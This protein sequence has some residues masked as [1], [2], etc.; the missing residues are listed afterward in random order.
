MGLGGRRW[1]SRIGGRLPDRARPKTSKAA[2]RHPY[3]G[4][5]GGS[6]GQLTTAGGLLFAGDAGGN[7]VAL[8]A[9]T[10]KPLWHAGLGSSSTAPQTYP[11][12]GRQQVLVAVGDTLYVFTLY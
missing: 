12:D 2:W 9:K 6:G 11:V 3:P 4:C 5:G 10:G 7:F 1:Q 8:D